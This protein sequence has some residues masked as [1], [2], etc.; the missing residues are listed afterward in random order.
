[1]ASK[2]V[3]TLITV[4][5]D[6]LVVVAIALTLRLVVGFFG[7]MAQQEW[8]KTLLDVTR[9]LV[10][11]FG[12]ESIETPYGGVFDVNATLTIVVLLFGEWL[13]SMLRRQA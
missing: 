10:V 9:F 2:P 12:I 1:M 8:G 13:L 5:M 6:I 7:V 4:F 11:P 3:R